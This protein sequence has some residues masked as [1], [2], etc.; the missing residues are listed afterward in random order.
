MVNAS[1][2]EAFLDKSNSYFP[3]GMQTVKS[4][5]PKINADEKSA[6]GG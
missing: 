3:L 6:C 2:F 1:L 4:H 5:D